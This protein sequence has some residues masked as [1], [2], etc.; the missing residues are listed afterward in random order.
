[1]A[2]FAETLGA[3]GVILHEGPRDDLARLRTLERRNIRKRILRNA[4]IRVARAL[5]RA[6]GRSAGKRNAVLVLGYHSLK[7]VLLYVFHTGEVLQR[8]KR[9]LA[10][11]TTKAA[12]L[13]STAS[14]HFGPK[15]FR[16]RR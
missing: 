9:A 1:M 8:K 2:F 6:V 7:K 10:C 16:I 12:S 13:R 15:S 4:P 14:R 11:E 3:F 5:I